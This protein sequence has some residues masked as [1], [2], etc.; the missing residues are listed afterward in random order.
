MHQHDASSAME[1]RPRSGLRMPEQSPLLKV[2]LLLPKQ[3]LGHLCVKLLV[4]PPM[5]PVL[6]LLS[7]SL[8]LPV[9]LVTAPE[10]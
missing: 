10:V 3:S 7:V 2:I 1:S 4:M 9:L 5:M 8:L 6:L